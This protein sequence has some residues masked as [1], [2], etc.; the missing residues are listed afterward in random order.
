MKDRLQRTDLT[1]WNRAGLSRLRYVDGNAISH[2]ETLR[3]GL[4]QAFNSD[5]ELQWPELEIDAEAGSVASKAER[6][7][8]QYLGP[9]R[10]YVWE[11]MRALARSAHVLTEHIDANSNETFLATA[12]E[13][14]NLRKLVA[15]LNYRPAPQSSAST[16]L[17]LMA[18]DGI[19]GTFDKGFGVKSKPDDGSAPI[20]FETLEEIE[21]DTALNT[22]QAADWNRSTATLAQSGDIVTFPL[23]AALEG[24]SIG[25]VGV[26][27][28][29]DNFVAVSLAGL[30]PDALQLKLHNPAPGWPAQPPLADVTL[31]L[32]ARSRRAPKISGQNVVSL[33]PGGIPVADDSVLT[34][35]QGGNWQAAFVTASEG[36]RLELDRNGPGDGTEVFLAL[37]AHRQHYTIDDEG[38]EENRIVLPLEADR[39]SGALFSPWLARVGEASVLTVSD[40]YDYLASPG[41]EWL[42]Y[43]TDNQSLKAISYASQ[44]SVELDGKAE[45]LSTGDLLVI[46][47]QDGEYSAARLESLDAD[48]NSVQLELTP[49]PVNAALIQGNFKHQLRPAGF[50]RNTASIT[51]GDYNIRLQDLPA[52]LKPGRKVIVSDGD[53]ARLALVTVVDRAENRI[54]LQ[55][56]AQGFA[57]WNT[58]IYGNAVAAGHGE[59]AKEKVLGSG[60]ATLGNQTFELKADDL[61]HIADAAFD[62]GVRADIELRV[63]DRQWQQVYSLD[64]SGAEDHHFAVVLLENGNASLSF[65]D[66]THGRRLPTGN[67]NVRVRYRRGAGLVGNLAPGS[68]V[69]TVG[70]H[71]WIDGFLQPLPASGGNDREDTA[72]LRDNAPASTLTL[73]RAVSLVDFQHLATSQS[74]VWQARAF[75][76]PADARPGETVRVVVLPAGG[77]ELGDLQQDL[78]SFLQQRAEPHVQVE[79]A[80]WQPLIFSVDAS[81]AVDSGAF[82]PEIVVDAVRQALLD[83]FSLVRRRLGAPLFRSEVMAAIEGVEGVSNCSAAVDAQLRDGDGEPTTAAR[84]VQAADGSVRRISA[85]PEQLLHLDDGLSSITISSHEWSL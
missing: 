67:N 14:E 61:S 27:A 36:S 79:V 6:L 21:L 81:I 57:A 83:T 17:A 70:S 18:A 24:T 4:A 42:Y 43:T 59:T 56:P 1:R 65:G 35:Y 68:L 71:P 47:D 25:D 69:K 73:G 33:Q 30:A 10:D 75:R 44:L 64:D 41:Y 62:Q 19:S 28:C 9:R 16:I 26:L 84:V 37:K 50:D 15:L 53:Q 13:W 49:S 55:P 58:V 5:S 77:G 23:A 22:L 34:W 39:Q 31:W 20:I 12:T 45:S 52:S 85:R 78:Q 8:L 51:D 3:Q 7:R 48:A 38:H 60:D 40:A 63:D 72:T 29:A 76:P 54:R 82:E 80:P 32:T 11:I 66:G 74:S 46:E 2:L